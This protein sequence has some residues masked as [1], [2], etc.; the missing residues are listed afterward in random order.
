MEY[1]MEIME[2]IQSVDFFIF[3]IVGAATGWLFGQFVKGGGLGLAI[4]I[5]IG[6]VGSII[7]G[8]IFDW[9]DFMNVSDFADPVI[10]GALGAVILLS[11]A[12]ALKPKETKADESAES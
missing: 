5:T 12:N 2:I 11:I 7:S 1:N 3:L 9:L 10:A 6:I 8:F 4:N